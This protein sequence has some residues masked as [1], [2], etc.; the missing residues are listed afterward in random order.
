MSSVLE[1]SKSFYLYISGN[2]KEEW[3]FICKTLMKNT[4]SKKNNNFT[5]EE[6]ENRH[7]TK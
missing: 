4:K 7:E 6:E 1:W 5:G 3:K 2:F